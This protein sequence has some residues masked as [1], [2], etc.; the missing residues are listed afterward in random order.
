MSS[1]KYVKQAVADV[2]TELNKVD[3]CSDTSIARLQGAAGNIDIPKKIEV[4]LLYG[5]LS[6]VRV[7]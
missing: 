6:D 5:S 7:F 1:E 2:E 4:L 3:Q